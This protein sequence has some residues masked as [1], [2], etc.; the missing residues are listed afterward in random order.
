MEVPE[1]TANDVTYFVSC[2][3]QKKK[4]P[5]YAKEL[6]VSPWFLKAREFVE[7]TGCQWF[8][9]SAEHGL[10][11]PDS[12]FGP[13]EKTLNQMLISDRR[14]WAGNVIAQIR[15]KIPDT[16]HVVIFAGQRYREFA[17]SARVNDTRLCRPSETCPAC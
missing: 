3:G 17:H 11:E 5:T 6:Y 15:E 4:A 16:K 9:L 2:V 7:A 8:I 12:V 10:V 1:P 14:R 13:Y